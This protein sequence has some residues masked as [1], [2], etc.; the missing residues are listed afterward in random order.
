[1]GSFSGSVVVCMYFFFFLSWVQ[2]KPTWPSGKKRGRRYVSQRLWSKPLSLTDRCLLCP[3]KSQH[4]PWCRWEEGIG[5]FCAVYNLP[6][7]M[8]EPPLVDLPE[9]SVSPFPEH[10]QCL[11]PTSWRW[12]HSLFCL[13]H[14]HSTNSKCLQ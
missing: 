3:W 1:M 2:F 8:W 13:H 11:L 5:W 4:P 7:L 9:C 6:G 14:R 10:V 12:A